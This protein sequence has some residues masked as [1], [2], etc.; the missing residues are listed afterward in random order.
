[1]TENDDARLVQQCLQGDEAAF[2]VL[3]QRHQKAVFNLALRM[4]RDYAEAQEVAQ[5]AFIKAYENLQAFDARYKFFSWLYR[6]AANTALNHA[7]RNRRFLAIE[8]E[9]EFATS[10]PNPQEDYETS[11]AGENV[12]RALMLLKP[13]YRAVLVL[14]HFDGLSYQEIS[15]VLGVPEKTVKSRLFSARQ[16]LKE[17]LLKQGYRFD[18]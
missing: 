12:Q 14:K 8:T 18:D 9:A 16:I 11:E 3:V 5:E 10:G 1:M 6:I 13:D 4:L 2:G 15:A 17:V 7:K